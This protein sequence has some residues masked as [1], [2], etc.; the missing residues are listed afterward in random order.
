MNDKITKE[1][2]LEDIKTN[3]E[4]ALNAILQLRNE[5]KQA[6][7]MYEGVN[8]DSIKQEIAT[9]VE[10]MRNE[11]E[12][13]SDLFEL[14]NVLKPRNIKKQG[15]QLDAKTEGL[16]YKNALKA[17]GKMVSADTNNK[18]LK[19]M[20]ALTSLAIASNLTGNKAY[21]LANKMT[22]ILGE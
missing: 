20:G 8:N 12:E 2:I 16:I 17:I 15:N 9:L 6:W 21:Q 7:K 3:P 19:A 13:L 5:T 14:K 22:K 4:E 1:A 18:R 11:N 10:V